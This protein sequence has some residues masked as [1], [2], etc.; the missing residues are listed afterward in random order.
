MPGVRLTSNGVQD[1]HW[2]FRKEV[3]VGTLL[4]IL[5]YGVM[6][7]ITVT[8]LRGQVGSNEERIGRIEAAAARVAV[9]ETRV[10]A[11]ERTVERLEER[12]VRSLSEIKA[13]LQRIEE[14]QRGADPSR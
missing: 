14:R 6:F 1:R 12:T 5:A 13:I 4:A 8:E 2:H 10:A 7:I 9:I 3:T 11:G